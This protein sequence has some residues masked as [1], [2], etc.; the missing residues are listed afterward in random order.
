MNKLNVYINY[1]DRNRTY[2][3][4]KI[5]YT[6]AA[7]STTEYQEVLATV[8]QD[9]LKLRDVDPK[10]KQDKDIV[11]AAVKQN[12]LALQYAKKFNDD[13]DVVR[14][15]VDQNDKALEYAFYG[16]WGFNILGKHRNGSDVDDNGYDKNGYD[17]QGFNRGG[18][19]IYT[20]TEFDYYGF[21]RN[22][23][24]R[25]RTKF[26]ENGFDKNGIHERGGRYS[27]GYNRD[28]FN[29]SGYHKVT[30]TLVDS[31]GF[32]KDGYNKKTGEF[33]NGIGNYPLDD[34]GDTDDEFDY[35][36]YLERDD[37]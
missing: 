8:Q 11:M 13:A 17:D 3:K 9:G 18:K 10:Y 21:K 36:D 26:D 4:Y 19:Y 2:K 22:G 16:F 12:G 31:Q 5:K 30:G 32:D 34:E 25:N 14:A 35:D 7:G 37:M 1:M 6:L 24:H 33:K 20:G 29:K 28:G 23:E 15:A 27:E